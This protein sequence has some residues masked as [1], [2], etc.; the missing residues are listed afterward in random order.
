MIV[1]CVINM[2]MNIVSLCSENV[3]C[4]FGQETMTV[5]VTGC[6]TVSHDSSPTKTDINSSPCGQ[7]LKLF[8]FFIKHNDTSAR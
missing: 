2:D 8:L 4:S 7:S 5:A 1:N 3:I 6:Y